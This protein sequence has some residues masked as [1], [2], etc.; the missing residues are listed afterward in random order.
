AE[1]EMAHRCYAQNWLEFAFGRPLQVR[2]FATVESIAD[3]SRDDAWSVKEILVALVD[4]DSFRTRAPLP[5]EE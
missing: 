3:G 4:S 2:D 1:S 5:E